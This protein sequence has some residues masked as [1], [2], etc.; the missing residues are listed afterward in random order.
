MMNLEFLSY[1]SGI[2]I[3]ANERLM[4]TLSLCDHFN[5]N[6]QFNPYEYQPFEAENW[7]V[8]Q[9]LGFGQTCRA[10]RVADTPEGMLMLYIHRP[11]FAADA[12]HQDSF[13]FNLDIGNERIIYR[14]VNGEVVIDEIGDYEAIFT[15]PEAP[16]TAGSKYSWLLP[17]IAGIVVKGVLDEKD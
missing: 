7:E 17:F 2:Q 12:T 16:A 5:I 14:E 8:G 13:D 11:A 1:H 3:R 6:M 10:V 15:C 9:V 4:Y